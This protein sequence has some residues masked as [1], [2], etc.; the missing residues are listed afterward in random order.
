MFELP[1]AMRSRIFINLLH[2]WFAAIMSGVENL[3]ADNIVDKDGAKVDWMSIT[4]PGKILG[5]YYSAHWCPPCRGFTPNL[6]KWYKEMKEK[7]AGKNFE[8]IFVSSDSDQAAFD[9]YYKEMP[10]LALKFEERQAKV[11]VY[12]RKLLC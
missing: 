2:L 1:A 4:G 5:L 9:E 3:L 11:C 12:Y 6:A 7:D 10:W 8:I